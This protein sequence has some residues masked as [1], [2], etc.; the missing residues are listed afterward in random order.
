[1]NENRAEYG[2]AVVNVSIGESF[3]DIVV[4]TVG[5]GVFDVDPCEFVVV[6]DSINLAVCNKIGFLISVNEYPSK[7]IEHPTGCTG[8][9]FS[10]E[11]GFHIF[12]KFV[13]ERVR[14]IHILAQSVRKVDIIRISIGFDVLIY[15]RPHSR[16]VVNGINQTMT[17]YIFDIYLIRHIHLHPFILSGE[18]IMYIRTF[19]KDRNEGVQLRMPL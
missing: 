1:V 11:P 9:C 6:L 10:K 4:T 8:F 2:A 13:M 17:Q 5:P 7:E 3:C 14:G 12:N 18:D 16:T 15:K 19:P